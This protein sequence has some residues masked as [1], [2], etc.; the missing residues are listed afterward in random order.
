MNDAEAVAAFRSAAGES[1]PRVRLAL[2]GPTSQ[3]EMISES[4][5]N[6]DDFEFTTGKTAEFAVCQSTV[7]DR[8]SDYS[9]PIVVFERIDGAN[10][11]SHGRKAVQDL[12]VVAVLKNSMYVD[13][14]DYNRAHFG[15]FSRRHEAECLREMLDA[16]GDF[17]FWKSPP[18]LSDEQLAKIDVLCSWESYPQLAGAAELAATLDPDRERPIDVFFA[19]TTDYPGS[20]ID[21]HRKKCVEAVQALRGM[22]VVCHAGRALSR[23]EYLRTMAD[24][25]IVVCPF[26]WGETCQ[27][28]YEAAML[29][30]SLIRPDCY[31]AKD[32]G[33]FDHSCQSS[34]CVRAADFRGLDTAC[35]YLLGEWKRLLCKLERQ[36]IAEFYLTRRASTL[37][38]L[39]HRLFLKHVAVTA[40]A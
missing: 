34:Y 11:A 38:T 20:P 6:A 23:D 4:A 1:R 39:F 18:E 31:W 19:G 3:A 14:Q 13:R 8:L 28:E 25:K 10:L 30:C 15:G 35:H 36:S 29:G 40:A 24:S 5:G 21:W 9:G 26:G 16:R 27:R 33:A 12:R 7:L 32:C 22:N 37:S 2:D 17:P